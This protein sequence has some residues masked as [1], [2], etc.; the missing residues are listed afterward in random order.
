MEQRQ[1]LREG[2]REGRGEWK[3]ERRGSRGRE[4]GLTERGRDPRWP[5]ERG[6]GDSRE[7][8]GGREQLRRERE[9]IQ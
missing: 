4:R 2:E 5:V 6:R 1:Q 7:K 8:E 3:G 9:M